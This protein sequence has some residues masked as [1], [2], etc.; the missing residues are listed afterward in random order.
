[1]EKRPGTEKSARPR[2][3]SVPLIG[4]KEKK[5]VEREKRKEKKLGDSLV[6]VRDRAT[7]RATI[8]AQK[9]LLEFHKPLK[10]HPRRATLILDRGPKSL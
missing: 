7:I 9:P 2:F 5:K 6:T 4:K 8:R 3:F 1:M 10:V